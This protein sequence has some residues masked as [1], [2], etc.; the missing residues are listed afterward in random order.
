MLTSYPVEF[1]QEALMM[2]L[3]LTRGRVAGTPEAVHACWNV[4]GY[5]LARTIVEGQVIV[6]NCITDDGDIIQEALK[7]RDDEE[8]ASQGIFPWLSVLAIVLRLIAK[9]GAN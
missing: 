8:A 1:P 7:A 2:V 6:G 9:Y 5:A 3:D 4:A